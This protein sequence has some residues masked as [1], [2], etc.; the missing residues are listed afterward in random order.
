MSTQA[1]LSFPSS[2][3]S[4]HSNGAARLPCPQTPHAHSQ[5]GTHFVQLQREIPWCETLSHGHGDQ[6]S[7]MTLQSSRGSL[8]PLGLRITG[9][10]AVTEHVTAH[11]APRQWEAFFR[12]L[13][14]TNAMLHHAC[15][16]DLLPLIRPDAGPR[17]SLL[18]AGNSIVVPAAPPRSCVCVVSL[19]SG[20]PW[21]PL[22]RI[23][24]HHA[25][26]FFEPGTSGTRLALCVSENVLDEAGAKPPAV[27]CGKD[28]Y[29]ALLSGIDEPY[30]KCAINS[31]ATS[32]LLSRH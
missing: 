12:A 10:A 2:W 29:S 9:E 13:R 6:E 24:L 27:I 26:I 18:D 28:A 31:A 14:S 5:L 7:D 3:S 20:P 30:K 25:V 1:V 32:G 11:A 8:H 4:P 16:I 22:K 17:A 23:R 21:V 19:H 15:H